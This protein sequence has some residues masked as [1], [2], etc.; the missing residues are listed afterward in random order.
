MNYE[1]AIHIR[2][3]TLAMKW[4]E[5]ETEGVSLRPLTKE[6]RHCPLSKGEDVKVTSPSTN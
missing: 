6:K 2:L 1:M 4:A 3:G 5:V